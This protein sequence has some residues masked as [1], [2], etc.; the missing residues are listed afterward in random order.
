MPITIEVFDEK[1][2]F[3][4]S[5]LWFR[6]TE[7][8]KMLPGATYSSKHHRWLAPMTWPTCKILRGIFGDDLIVGPKLAQWAYDLWTT[9]INP[10]M[11]SRESL[12][13]DEEDHS[14]LTEIIRS[15]Q[16]TKGVPDLYPFQEAGV[17]FLTIVQAALLCD[18]MGTGKTRQAIQTLRAAYESTPRVMPFPAI[19]VCPKNMMYT[20]RDEFSKWWPQIKVNIITGTAVVRRKAIADKAHVY[21]INFEGVRT[22]SRLSGFGSIKLKRCT[23]CDPTLPDA[24]EN[25]PT[26]C[27]TCKKELNTR[28][29]KTV[30]IDEAHRMKEPKAK[31]TRACWALRTEETIFRFPLTGTPI[32]NAPQDL[33]SSLHFVAP[34]EWPARSQYIDRYCLQ[35][36]SPFGPMTVI[37]LKPDKK[38]EFF[39]VVDP[40]LRRMPKSVVLT[41]L[42]EKTYQ[43]RY[44][45][46]SLPQARA[47][48]K[49]E[50][51]MIAKLDEGFSVA[52]NQLVQLTRLSQFA[53]SY[54]E[55]DE[56]GDTRLTLPS[57]KIDTL[58]EV[59]D[60]MN[61]APA[62]IFAESR[63]LIELACTRMEKIGE[64]FVKIVGGQSAEERQMAL[65][66]FQ[67]TPVRLILC[68]IAAGGIGITLTKANTAIFL[69]R[70][71][72]MVANRQA[73]DRIHRIGSEIHDSV[74]IID[75]ISKNTLE[76]RQRQVLGDKMELMEEIVRDKDLLKRVLGMG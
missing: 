49:M 32:A 18:D 21:I 76:D 14:P 9:R 57:N 36:F 69:Q 37:G 24:L 8:I 23:K 72:S 70:S 66:A 74:D 55:I 35:A 51:G 45:E 22:H 5:D 10:A 7:R 19:I 50:E 38:K 47:Y 68:T 28:T 52:G 4:E 75:I 13:L 58:I 33:W 54:A 27:E 30:I 64:K 2:V 48:K 39:S 65:H 6:D 60:D 62:V 67:N 11:L 17:K 59:L 26:K 15:W 71:W 73:E 53:S 40:R 44:S 42:P 29:W 1:R 20:W 16:G 31:Q 41:Q 56:N 43:T 12:L 61:G 3:V 34:K 25:G 46:M 63:Q